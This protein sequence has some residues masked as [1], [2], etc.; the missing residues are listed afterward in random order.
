MHREPRANGLYTHRMIPLGES[1][2][3]DV[4]VPAS[5]GES[6]AAASLKRTEDVLGKD[7]IGTFELKKDYLRSLRLSRLFFRCAPIMA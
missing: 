1:A 3:N 6:S 2:G 7:K 5:S 4:V